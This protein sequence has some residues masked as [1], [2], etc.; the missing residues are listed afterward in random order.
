M[1]YAVFFLRRLLLPLR[2]QA[3]LFLTILFDISIYLSIYLSIYVCTQD[4][5]MRLSCRSQQ[6]KNSIYYR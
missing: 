3:A 6:T 5:L 2:W 4:L 1:K